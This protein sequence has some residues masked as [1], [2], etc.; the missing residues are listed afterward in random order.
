MSAASA[1]GLVVVSR[2]A[3]H[4]TLFWRRELTPSALARYDL[5]WLLDCDVRV[6]PHLL[7]LREV[8][9]WLGVTGASIVQP[10]VV[11]SRVGGARSTLRWCP[12]NWGV[13]GGQQPR[14]FMHHQS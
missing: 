2:V 14:V 12:R 11:P 3:G 1:P 8:E 13:L 10:S 7:S 4:K 9:H 6:S 5:V